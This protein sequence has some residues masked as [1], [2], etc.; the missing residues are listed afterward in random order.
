MYAKSLMAS[1]SAKWANVDKFIGNM[2]LNGG[3]TFK[4][5]LF[6]SVSKHAA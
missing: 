6:T 3:I 2:L 1:K 4:D 5:L